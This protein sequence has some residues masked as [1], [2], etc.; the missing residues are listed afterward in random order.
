MQ[1]TIFWCVPVLPP[2]LPVL[3]REVMEGFTPRGFAE[4]GAG[5]LL[6]Y[7]WT[8]SSD[9]PEAPQAELSLCFSFSA[10][11]ESNIG[12]L[13]LSLSDRRISGSTIMCFCCGLRALA[14]LAYLYR[15]SIPA[16][17]LP[18]W[19]KQ[20]NFPQACFLTFM[21]ESVVV[22]LF[23]CCNSTSRLLLGSQ[24]SHT[25]EGASRNV[26]SACG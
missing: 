18:G 5:K 11:K 4:H 9:H 16:S 12:L 3:Q 23:S 25:S 2:E 15:Q 13:N 8:C 24:L 10:F 17:E 7:R 26:S 19:T 14:D 20:T 1:N 21:T 6:S 22:S